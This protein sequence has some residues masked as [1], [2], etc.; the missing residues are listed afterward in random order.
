[1]QSCFAIGGYRYIVFAID[2]HS[3]YVFFELIKTKDEADSA[4][5][6]IIA[7]IDYLDDGSIKLHQTK[8]VEKIVERFLPNGPSSKVQRN[9]LP[10]SSEFLHHVNNAISQREPMHPELVRGLHA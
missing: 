4:V 6:R 1:M 9:S 5:K 3:R 2:E 7:E 10:Y 8:Y